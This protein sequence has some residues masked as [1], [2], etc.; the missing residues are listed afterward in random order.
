WKRIFGG[1]RQILNKNVRMD[2]DLYRIVGVMPAGFYVPGGT[3]EERNIEIWAA[4][5]FFGAPLP[6][7]PA[8]N[9]R[10]LPTAIARLKPGLT[11][12]AAQNRL[13]TLV[14][15]LQEKFP[16]D[17][18]QQNA[19]RMKLLPLKERMIGNLRQSL[20]LLLAAVGLVLL[21]G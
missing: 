10:N 19:W 2:T 13:E 6:D 12:A 20:V 3:A 5:S 8:R 16:G 9:R 17:Y 4:S 15:S 21:I 7:H 1:D 11:I 14:A 18:P